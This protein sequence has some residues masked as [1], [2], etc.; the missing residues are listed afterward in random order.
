MS[1]LAKRLR[2]GRRGKLQII[3]GPSTARLPNMLNR[4]PQK[5]IQRNPSLLSLFTWEIY[6]DA[7]I[8]I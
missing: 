3:Y 6:Y 2:L 7:N 4:S 1:F 5:R 8:S